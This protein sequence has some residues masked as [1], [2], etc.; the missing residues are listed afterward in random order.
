M[1]KDTNEQSE[2]EAL[3][4][5]TRSVP[6]IGK[7][8]SS[9]NGGAPHTSTMWIYSPISKPIESSCSRDFIESFI[10]SPLPPLLRGCWGDESSNPLGLPG[11][12]SILK[13]SPFPT[14]SHCLSIN[15]GVG[16]RIPHE[17]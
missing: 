9:W 8:L 2:E 13:L 15:S 12:Q 4:M 1:I 5:K 7:L 3:G 17:E 14:L 11:D 6:S 10:C 16:K